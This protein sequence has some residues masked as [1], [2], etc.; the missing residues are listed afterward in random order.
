MRT[1]FYSCR[2]A[3]EACFIAFRAKRE[4]Q[5]QGRY[6]GV[7][8]ARNGYGFDPRSPDV[9][10]AFAGEIPSGPSEP[11][12]FRRDRASGAIRANGMGFA[13]CPLKR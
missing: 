12:F 5:A 3:R 4:K 10:P 7:T 11:A 8:A 9:P 1:I 13:L 2:F 6:G